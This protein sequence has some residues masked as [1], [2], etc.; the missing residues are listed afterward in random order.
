[1][2]P[3]PSDV[4]CVLLF[5]VSD[6]AEELVVSSVVVDELDYPKGVNFIRLSRWSDD[7]ILEP[8]VICFVGII[9]CHNLMM[10]LSST[11]HS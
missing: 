7:T 10:I 2:S 4:E 11:N 8:F 6:V 5:L 9:K 3:S 1:M